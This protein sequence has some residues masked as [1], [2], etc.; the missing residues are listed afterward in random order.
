MRSILAVALALFLAGVSVS[1][2]VFVP[3]EFRE[4]VA[5][6]G[7]I[8]R[9]HVT[10]VRTVDVPGR[11]VDSIATVAVE[12]V[13]KGNASQF[14]PVRVPGG[15]SGRYRDVLVGAPVLGAG[16]RAVFFLWRD[17]DGIWR[18]VG[19]S[20]GVYDVQPDPQTG[21]PVV[22]PPVV[23]GRTAAL[24][25]VVRGDA[26]RKLLSVQEFESLVQLIMASRGVAVPRG[27]R[28]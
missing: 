13:I 8:V 12:N 11:G 19:L 21:R 4:V 22:R 23:A 27:G 10:D 6:A 25:P 14:V 20:M 18:P 28:Q 16:A 15:V 5:D 17:G 7:L 3:T 2:T 1:A 26:R 9:G 24:G